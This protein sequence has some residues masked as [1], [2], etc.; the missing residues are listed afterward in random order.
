MT[1]S[2]P[3]DV[4]SYCGADG[5]LRPL[6]IRFEDD[7]HELHKI[8]IQTIH[9]IRHITFVGLEA[10]IFLCT[11]ILFDRSIRFELKYAIRSHCWYLSQQLY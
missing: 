3:V 10:Q 11:G 9:D 8:N 1:I 4:I 7:A 2:K 5:E 6:R